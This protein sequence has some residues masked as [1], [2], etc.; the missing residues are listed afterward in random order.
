MS[1]F[2]TSGITDEERAAIGHNPTGRGVLG[3]L[4]DNP[5]P[6]RLVDVSEHPKSTGFPPGH[7]PMATFLGVP[8]RVEEQVFGNLYLAEKI[9]GL[10]FTPGDEEVVVALAAAAGIAIH[11]AELYDVSSK[12]TQWLSAAAEMTTAF[13]SQTPRHEALQLL[14]TRARTVA[15]VDVAAILLGPAD[16]LIVEVVEGRGSA[17]EEGDEIRADGPIA[18]VIEERAACVEEGGDWCAEFELEQAIVAPMQSAGTV[19]GVLVLGRASTAEHLTIDQDVTM[20]AGFAEQAALAIQLAGA[21]SDRVRLG[22]YEERDRIARDLHDLVVQRLFAVGLSLRQLSEQQFSSDEQTRRL[23]QA[24]DDMDGTV[25]E[26]RRSIFRLHARPGEGDLRSDLEG[27]VLESQA[28]LGYLPAFIVKGD[29]RSVPEDLR[30][31]LIAVLRES[32]SNVAR[33]ADA[34]TLSPSVV[35]NGNVRLTV[36]DDGRGVLGGRHAGGM[37]NMR[38]R[39][40][41]HGGECE[42]E[43]QRKGEREWCGMCRLRRSPATNVSATLNARR[44]NRCLSSPLHSQLAQQA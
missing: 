13:L 30:A 41:E 25:R 21:Q 22:I 26:L 9:G 31:G 36:A 44:E 27:I 29:V 4:I 33:H 16:G 18:L 20:A 3:V 14:C 12:R 23:E 1:E 38:S 37:A 7:P 5:H 35:D 19:L 24:V 34:S 42:F 2:V 10:P 8:V 39:A 43:R 11:K 40:T 6:L 15:D 32:L 28:T 17:L